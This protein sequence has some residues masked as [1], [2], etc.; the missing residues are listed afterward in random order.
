MTIEGFVPGFV[1][2]ARF[3]FK[4]PALYYQ[5]TMTLDMKSIRLPQN[6][7]ADR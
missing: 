5:T 7:T 6:L 2:E 4:N 3:A 1:P